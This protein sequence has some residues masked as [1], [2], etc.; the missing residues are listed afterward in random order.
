VWDIFIKKSAENIYL[1]ARKIKQISKVV[2]MTLSMNKKM[3][4]DVKMVIRSHTSKMDKQYNCQMEKNKN[5]Q[6][7]TTTL[8]NKTII[9]YARVK[10]LEGH[11]KH[12]LPYT[13]TGYIVPM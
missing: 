6:L 11:S 8:H 7:S 12:D 2:R 13:Y 3:L 1:S 4:E 9:K 10:R 5:K